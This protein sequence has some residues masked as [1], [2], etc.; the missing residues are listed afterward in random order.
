MGDKVIIL[1]GPTATGKTRLSLDLASRLP[2]ICEIVNV[3]SL[4][5]YNELTIGT[6][7][8]SEE[9]RHS[10][11]H[12][13]VD[14]ESIKHPVNVAHF[15]RLAK[16]SIESILTSGR[17][18][19]LVGASAFYLRALIKGMIPSA[20]PSKTLRKEMEQTYRVQ[21]I[22]PFLSYLEDNDPGSLRDIHENDHYRLLRAVEHHRQTG[23]P[24]SRDKSEFNAQGPYDFSVN[25][26]PQWDILHIHTDIP[27]D[28]HFSVIFA[29]AKNM[30]D[31]GLLEEVEPLL[32]HRSLPPLKSV[33]YREAVAY[34]MGEIS[35]R[36]KLV[37]RMAI[38]TRQLARAQKKFFKKITPK[39]ALCPMG[40]G[41]KNSFEEQAKAFL[42]C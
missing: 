2:G 8:P 41:G 28:E 42:H 24:F 12:H 10:V 34:L 13:L 23:R 18:P 38:S 14:I 16:D 6:A 25:A 5:F 26:H 27:P 9:E 31:Q 1:S 11:P 4:L 40:Q 21:G 29:R 17:T 22:E 15:C 19:L 30:V 37:E 36:E 33:G 7:K 32:P 20:P 39:T 35:S 3:D